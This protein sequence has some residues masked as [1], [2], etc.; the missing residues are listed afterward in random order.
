MIG[1]V[2]G[3][4]GIV[5]LGAYTWNRSLMVTDGWWMLVDVTVFNPNQPVD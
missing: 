4:P 2:H 3:L 5:G 1:G